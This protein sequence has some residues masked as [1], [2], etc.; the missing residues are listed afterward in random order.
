MDQRIQDHESRIIALEKNYGEVTTKLLTVENGQLEIKNTIL[1]EFSEAKKLTNKMID[2]QFK[3]NK[4]KL[5]SKEKIQ[6][7]WI[8]AI[9]TGVG[10][11]GVV[12]IIR[13]FF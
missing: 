4:Q 10:A 13:L 12:A 3:F 11:G 2:H 5:S 9:S 7:A 8:A 6:L 1:K